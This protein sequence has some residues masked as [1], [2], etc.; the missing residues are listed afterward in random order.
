M[1]WSHQIFLDG[2]LDEG[3]GLHDWCEDGARL[4]VRIDALVHQLARLLI[5]SRAACARGGGFTKSDSYEAKDTW[6][7]SP[8]GT[9]FWVLLPGQVRARNVGAVFKLNTQR[10]VSGCPQRAPASNTRPHSRFKGH[11]LAFRPCSTFS[12]HLCRAT[13]T[14]DEKT[15]FGCEEKTCGHGNLGLCRQLRV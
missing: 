7:A 2:V 4:L 3:C 9:G 14:E 5:V 6:E 13:F 12:W 15:E 1:S 8:A 10:E 11:L